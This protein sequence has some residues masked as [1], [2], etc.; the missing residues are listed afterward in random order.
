[1]IIFEKFKEIFETD[2]V[3]VEVG[4]I[5]NDT[6]LMDLENWDSMANIS[7]NACLDENYGFTMSANELMSLRVYGDIVE[8]ISKRCSV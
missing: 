7:L 6:V 1:M 8:I 2:I 3:M 5:S 4:T